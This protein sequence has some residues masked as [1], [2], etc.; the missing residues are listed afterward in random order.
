M[1]DEVNVTVETDDNDSASVDTVE[2]AVENA[3][4]H[5]V[6]NDQSFALG[7]LTAKVGELTEKVDSAVTM[8]AAANQRIDDMVQERTISDVMDRAD[9]RVEE[10][11]EEAEA[12][13]EAVE[14]AASDG[15]VTP[16]EVEYIEEAAD[17]VLDTD[18]EPKVKEHFFMRKWGS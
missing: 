11:Q 12:L 2:N 10:A 4:D 5:K 16:D 1:S 3:V 18:D 6:E 7:A 13:A 14:E 15:V 9:D 8:A 17:V